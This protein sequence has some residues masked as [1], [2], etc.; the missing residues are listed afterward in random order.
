[1][2]YPPN[3]VNTSRFQMDL[4]SVSTTPLG[5]EAASAP[6]HPWQNTALAWLVLA[7]PPNWRCSGACSGRACVNH[8][9]L[10]F[11]CFEMVFPSPC[12]TRT[13]LTI[14][15]FSGTTGLWC[16]SW[17]LCVTP[18]LAHLR[19]LVSPSLLVN[20]HNFRQFRFRTAFY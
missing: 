5:N 6:S 20:S 14:G 13:T 9:F 8:P 7:S 12:F 19:S 11:F 10:P 2:V 15:G 1:M 18:V 17:A 16:E 3:S 4:E